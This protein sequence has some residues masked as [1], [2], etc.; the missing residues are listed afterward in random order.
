MSHVW[1]ARTFCSATAATARSKTAPPTQVSA[2]SISGSNGAA[3][4]D[5]DNDG[6]PDL[7]VTA[8]ADRRC[9]L[10]INDGAGRFT[11]EA[12]SRGAALASEHTHVGFSVAVGDY[13][14]DGWLDLHTTEFRTRPHGWFGSAL[15]RPLAAQSRR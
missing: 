3:W 12:V 1:T 14:R 11:E 2:A 4:A 8:L 10:F 9:Y 13:D 5:I 7:Y 15:P 6:D